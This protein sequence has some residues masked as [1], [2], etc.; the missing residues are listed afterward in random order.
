VTLS[1][2]KPHQMSEKK[3]YIDNKGAKVIHD[4]IRKIIL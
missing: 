1:L 2:S 4:K 3:D